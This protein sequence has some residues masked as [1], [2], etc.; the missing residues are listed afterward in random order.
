MTRHIINVLAVT[1]IFAL[2]ASCKVGI[3]WIEA[4][5]PVFETGRC[6]A[7]CEDAS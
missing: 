7:H 4:H 5:Q 2:M 6:L 3:A 1:I